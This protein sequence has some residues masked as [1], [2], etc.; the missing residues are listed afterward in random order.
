MAFAKLFDTTDG[1]IL[2]I[3]N[4]DEAGDPIITFMFEPKNGI[5][6][7]VSVGYAN[8]NSAQKKRDQAFESLSL[9][10]VVSLRNEWMRHF[11]SLAR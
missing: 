2:A 3:K 1:Q 9:E 10:A 8:A 6:A 11:P 7:Q 4:D 5:Q